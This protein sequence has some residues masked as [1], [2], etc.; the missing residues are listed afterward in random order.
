MGFVCK[1]RVFGVWVRR[2]G[3]L[4]L[5]TG[6]FLGEG[7]DGGGCG[8]GRRRRRRRVSHVRGDGE[9]DGDGAMGA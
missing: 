6:L 9:V 2:G 3:L 5:G 1:S 7:D 8:D 4:R